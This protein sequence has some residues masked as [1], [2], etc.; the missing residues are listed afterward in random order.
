MGKQKEWYD[1]PSK[2]LKVRD[3]DFRRPQKFSREQIESIREIYQTFARTFGSTIGGQLRSTFELNVDDICQSFYREFISS[4]PNPTCLGLIEMDPLKGISLIEVNSTIIL[5]LIDRLLGGHGEV[6]EVSG[7]ELT[8]IELE[9]AKGILGR[10]FE[11]LKRGWQDIERF[12]FRLKDVAINPERLQLLPPEEIVLVAILNIK[13]GERKGV[14]RHCIPS[15]LLD[16]IAERLTSRYILEEASQVDPELVERMRQGIE[17]APVTLIAELGRAEISM[18]DILGL[19]IGDVVKL[20]SK[21]NDDLVLKI[22]D[23]K[24]FLCRPGVIGSKMAVQ[25]TQIDGRG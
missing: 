23:K 13:I 18:A 19:Q 9:V 14:M 17:I 5:V 8:E 6:K 16:P 25:I 21:V 4:L 20:T 12:N 1:V 3:Y 24:K 15:N 2:G 22:T 10:M 7:R 11:P